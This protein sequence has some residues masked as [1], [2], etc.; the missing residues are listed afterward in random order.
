MS[1]NPLISVIIP[2]YNVA[3]YLP[4][5]LDSVYQQTY[6][7]LEIILVDDGST[8]N[9]L[10]ICNQYAKQDKRIVVIHQ[11][12]GGLSA[13]RNSGMDHMQG[14]FFTF[15]D[16]DDW[17]TPDYCEVLFQAIKKS[18]ADVSASIFIHTWPDNT[19]SSPKGFPLTDL[20]LEKEELSLFLLNIIQCA[21]MKLFRA[22][23]AKTL[24]FDTHYTLYEDVPFSFFLQQQIRTLYYTPQP[25]Y[26][27]FQRKNSAMH[28]ICLEGRKRIIALQQQMEEY[29][30]QQ[31]FN[32]AQKL[33]HQFY[34]KASLIFY[35]LSVLKNNTLS[36]ELFQEMQDWFKENYLEL[37][38]L[39][40]LSL[41]GHIF[42]TMF[43]YFP[44]FTV[45]FF[46]CPI[47]RGL[48]RKI[49]F[50]YLSLNPNS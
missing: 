40:I 30:K 31:K 15:I 18:G 1:E 39:D 38:K 45:S 46:Q 26:C 42:A 48:L 10:E 34:L 32:R 9:S 29:Y 14:E 11:E 22:S 24:R 37:S 20:L 44:K 21:T 33:I 25:T 35:F 17:V 6:N 4:R 12:N 36:P 49:I 7:N 2:V 43:Y 23:L 3:K 16:S 19:H 13:A 47:W 50:N 5:C 27:Y 28:A 8:D 41:F